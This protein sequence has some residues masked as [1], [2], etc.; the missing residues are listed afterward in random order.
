MP[1]KLAI[2][3]VIWLFV[4]FLWHKFVNCYKNIP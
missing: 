2:N 1:E 3:L 4:V